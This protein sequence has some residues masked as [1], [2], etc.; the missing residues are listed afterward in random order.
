LAGQKRFFFWKAIFEPTASSVTFRPA[1]TPVW[2]RPEVLLAFF[3]L[4]VCDSWLA[5]PPQL[6]WAPNCF[7][8]V[9]GVCLEFFFARWPP[10]PRLRRA[11][12]PVADWPL[13]P[14]LERLVNR[15]PGVG[16]GLVHRGDLPALCAGCGRHGPGYIGRKP[17]S[18]CEF[19]RLPACAAGFCAFLQRHPCHQ[20]QR[21]MNSSTPQKKKKIKQP[22]CHQNNL[23]KWNVAI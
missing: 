14:V 12:N 6:N 16:D 2:R 7:R 23:P 3:S 1:T 8:I 22:S 21:Q 4:R 17:R 13:T 15:Y 10:S 5:S 19:R 20:R 11:G 18:F 9:A